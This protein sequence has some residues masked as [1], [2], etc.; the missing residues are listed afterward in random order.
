MV[1]DAHTRATKLG[2]LGQSNAAGE[3]ASSASRTFAKTPSTPSLPRTD[4]L[5]SYIGIADHNTRHE[6]V[7]HSIDEWVVGDVHTNTVEGVWPLFKRSI[8][9]SLIPS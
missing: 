4:E 6:T 3:S 7:N 2:L 8:I 1:R 9:G 5:K